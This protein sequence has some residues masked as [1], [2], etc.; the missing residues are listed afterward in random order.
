MGTWRLQKFKYRAIRERDYSAYYSAQRPQ[1]LHGC[2]AL[3]IYLALGSWGGGLRQLDPVLQYPEP[4][5]VSLVA[6]GE[7]SVA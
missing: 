4:S 1:R 2:I 6:D 5:D 7:L 3:M